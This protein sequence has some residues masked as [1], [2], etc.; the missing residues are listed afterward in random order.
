MKSSVSTAPDN[1]YETVKQFI[2]GGFCE[3][4]SKATFTDFEPASGKPLCDVMISDARDVARAVSCA[5]RAFDEGEWAAL[6]TAERAYYLNTIADLMEARSEE[7]AVLEARDS[8]LPIRFVKGGHIPRAIAH[9]R[10]F[11]EEGQRLIG[12]VYPLED[13][14]LNLVM[15]EPIGV[16][17]LI[18]PWNAPLAVTSMQMAAALICGN[19]CVIKPSEQT[20][21]TTALLGEILIAAE[22]PAGVVN[23]VQGAGNPTGQALVNHPEVDVISFTGGMT[24]GQ[25]VMADAAKGLKKLALEL[26]GKSANI[27]FSDAELEEAL[28]STML[29]MFANNGEVCTAGS[30][31]LVQRSLFDEF[32]DRLKT[33]IGNLKIGNPLEGETEI[34]PLISRQHLQRVNE[35]I[36][37]G[38]AEGAEILCG[39]NNVASDLQEGYYV[40]PT[41]LGNVHNRMQIAQ[42]EIFGPVAVIIPFEDEDEA[43]SIAND[44]QFGLSAYIWTKDTKLALQTA[45]QLRVGTVSI[46]CPMI[47]DFRVPFGGYKKSGLGRTGGQYSIDIFTEIKTTC[48]PVNPYQFPRLGAIGDA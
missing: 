5:R 19:T 1:S 33:R 45:R 12:E 27:I 23:I 9:F 10:Y 47:R 8:G 43:I 25:K 16:A 4:D 2:D 41:L 29:C 40:Q 42:E 35:F 3:S 28:D 17:A 7:I 15:R 48:L 34:G 22:L 11:A 36:D 30:R 13:A 20:P 31:I 46:N 37:L 14:Y 44:N 32:A 21:L 24:T 18:T 6:S 38:V 26:G 39:G